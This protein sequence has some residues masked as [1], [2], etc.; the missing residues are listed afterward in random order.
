MGRVDRPVDE[1]T[2]PVDGTAS[3]AG[4]IRNGIG[5]ATVT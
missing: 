5:T 2:H 1:V 3:E 4:P